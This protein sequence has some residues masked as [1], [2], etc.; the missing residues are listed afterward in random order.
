MTQALP[1]QPPEDAQPQLPSDL[2]Q[3]LP[4][5]TVTQIASWLVGHTLDEVER[6]LIHHTLENCGGDRVLAA[7]VLGISR[8]ALRRKM[9]A[10]AVRGQA[11]PEPKPAPAPEP[12][13]A[14]SESRAVTPVPQADNDREPKPAAAPLKRAKRRMDF[15][16][17][18]GGA[19]AAGLIALIG[20][21]LFGGTGSVS[22]FA[23]PERP[24]IELSVAERP[25]PFQQRI[26][27][28][29]WN[30]PAPLRAEAAVMVDIA[31]D[32][33]ME[34]PVRAAISPSATEADTRMELAL[35]REQD[36]RMELAADSE[37]DTRM[38]FAADSEQ[39][40]RMELAALPETADGAPETTGLTES[41][42]SFVAPEDVPAPLA[43][44]VSFAREEPAAPMRRQPARP[45]AAPA[46]TAA[47]APAV[48]LLFPFNIFAAGHAQ[49]AAGGNT[50]APADCCASN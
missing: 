41:A 39:D 18:I 9:T 30:A 23:A 3:D 34:P 19:L 1:K 17:L 10:Y 11:L 2:P 12:A 21:G 33:R 4:Q 45:R 15:R 40:T 32:K 37:Q 22:G 6:E 16:L 43:R 38:E 14:A 42:S 7:S 44:P 5:S 49:R 20:L 48:P 31:A 35:D 13:E 25:L 29:T 28:P 24:R 50:P 8:P 46:Q 36:I 47:P 26:I 27:V